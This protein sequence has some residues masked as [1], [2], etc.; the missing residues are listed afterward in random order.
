[1]LDPWPPWPPTQG[2]CTPGSVKNNEHCRSDGPTEAKCDKRYQ[3][4]QGTI[5]THS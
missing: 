5:W 2:A 1:M 3:N 4:T